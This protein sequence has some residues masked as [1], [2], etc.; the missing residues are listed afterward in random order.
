M[1]YL[2]DNTL[3]HAGHMKVP[4]VENVACVTYIL[5]VVATRELQF[6]I[7]GSAM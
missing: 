6:C 5:V 7:G 3:A 2:L 1:T 4:Y